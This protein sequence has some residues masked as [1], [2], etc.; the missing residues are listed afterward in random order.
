MT[1]RLHGY[2]VSNY[3]NIA[4]AALIEKGVGFEA[5]LARASQEQP[6]LGHSPMGKIPVLETEHGWL[7]ETVAILDYLDDAYPSVALRPAEPFPRARARQI[8]N[9]VQ[10]Y[11]EAPARALFPGVF[12]GSAND[13]A[14][15]A[16]SG[17]T[18]ERATAALA[19]LMDPRP[20]LF[21]DRPGQADLFAFYNLDLAGRVVE[22]VYG[23][24]LLTEIGG[25]E[26]WEARMR[27]RASS[28]VVLADF[29]EYFSQYL[30]DRGSA[31]GARRAAA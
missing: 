25:L 4:R 29:E 14:T 24:S 6:F 7:G 9:V 23:R 30:I 10:M 20:F 11:V 5:V 17:A 2:P 22:H 8:V 28:R 31:Y 27:E 26:G 1:L 12:F 19:R 15:E 18:L 21:G 16:A 3:F 13:P